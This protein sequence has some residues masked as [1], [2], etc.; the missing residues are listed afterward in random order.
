[1][2]TFTDKLGQ[3]PARGDKAEAIRKNDCL[4]DDQVFETDCDSIFTKYRD[5][6]IDNVTYY[7]F[8]MDELET[9]RLNEKIYFVRSD[10]NRRKLKK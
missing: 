1:M 5:N 8:E 10:Q 3:R 6:T 4:E 2:D 9:I 7:C